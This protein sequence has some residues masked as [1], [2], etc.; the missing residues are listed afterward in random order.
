MR[1]RHSEK[2]RTASSCSLLTPGNHSRKSSAPSFRFAK[3][4]ATGMRVP[5]NNHAPLIL[6]GF[7]STTAHFDQLMF[8]DRRVF[9]DVQRWIFSMN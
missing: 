8:K 5:R 3:K 2:L 1:L 7:R 9:Y 6:F 4:V